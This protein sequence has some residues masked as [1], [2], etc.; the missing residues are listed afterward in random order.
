MFQTR[1][2]DGRGALN[3][4]NFAN[5]EVDA[6]LARF[7]AARTD[8]EAQDAYHDLHAL[9]AAEL[10]YL[11]LWRLDTKSAW[12]NEVR[13]NIISPYFYFTDFDGWKL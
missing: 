13:N 10:P 6:M 7:D 2:A 11:F 3:V 1:S 4:L 8:T 5:K 12:R 9:L